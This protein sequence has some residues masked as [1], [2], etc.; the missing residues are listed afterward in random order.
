ML[1]PVTTRCAELG[2]FRIYNIDGALEF[3]HSVQDVEVTRVDGFPSSQQRT[4]SSQELELESKGYI[5][6]PNLVDMEMGVGVRFQNNEFE[7]DTGSN[8]TE[9]TLYSFFGNFN[10]LRHKPYPVYL[11]Y[12][13]RNPTVSVD[14]ADSLTVEHRDYGAIFSLEKPLVAYPMKLRINHSDSSG[15]SRG[16]LIDSE[17][18]NLQFNLYV[19]PSDRF[20]GSLGL[21][22]SRKKSGSGSLELP[23]Q[24]T[25]SEEFGLN[26]SSSYLFGKEYAHRFDNNLYYTS[27]ESGHLDTREDIHFTSYLELGHSKDFNTFYRYDI[28]STK[29]SETNIKTSNES[30]SANFLAN[31]NEEITLSGG[32]DTSDEKNE[33]FDRNIHGVN[34]SIR[35]TT[36]LSDHFA[37]NTTYSFSYKFNKQDSDVFQINRIGESHILD[38]LSAV[39]LQNEFVV[40]GS[41]TVSNASRS[42]IY[43]EGIDYRLTV[44]GVETR[45]ERLITGNI[46][47]G[48]T[49]LVDYG[50][51]SGGS[52]DYS[53]LRQKIGF[54]LRYDDTYNFSLTFTKNEETLE[55]GRPLRPLYTREKALASVDA[56]YRLST[57]SNLS[58]GIEL[59]KESGD[60]RPYMREQ[61]DINFVVAL[62]LFSSFLDLRSIYEN[63][64]NEFSE[65]DVD[66]RHHAAR[67]FTRY[68]Y[69]ST[70]RL[71]L[72]IEEDT[73]GTIHRDTTRVTLEYLWRWRL[74][75]FAVEGRYRHDEQG[76]V[77]RK[78]SSVYLTLTREF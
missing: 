66:L 45:I 29:Y 51:E 41:V 14:L 30:L 17:I 33:G 64:D 65:E 5:Y 78:D 73:G 8:E 13:Q 68:G 27:V 72:A 28:N 61:A 24:N 47:D 52:F 4:I 18:D 15:K 1:I 23:I 49:V 19:D 44:V 55:A 46:P 76:G 20:T 10:L 7:V 21:F 43:I 35:Y 11:H 59:E 48:E 77:S 38:G 62:P 12:S 16:T 63:I 67:L 9:E 25:M 53:Y 39:S 42:Q 71:E 26:A 3:G 60:F 74:L 50:F 2:M 56:R 57:S 32:I 70:S 37:F 40:P 75:S 54:G 6:H 69:R 22:Q 36:D 34:S 31:L 58:W